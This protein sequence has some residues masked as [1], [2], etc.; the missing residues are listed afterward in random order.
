M[1]ALETVVTRRTSD[2]EP[3]LSLLAAALGEGDRSAFLPTAA[4]EAARFLGAEACEVWLE[5]EGPV[6]AAVYRRPEAAPRSPDPRLLRRAQAGDVVADEGWL[7]V[8]VPGAGRTQG[9]LA[10]SHPAGT[11]LGNGGAV[12]D[13]DAL[14]AARLVAALVGLAQLGLGTERFDAEARDQFLALVGHDLRSPL[15]N[16]RVGAQL[17]RRN[18]D[19]GDL[20]SVREALG[21][22]E[23]Q[24]DRLLA[25]LEALLE[26]IAAAG[27]RLI[28]LQ[29]LDLAAM[30]ETIVGP[31]R[32]AAEERGT[33]TVF[34]VQPSPQPL[35]ARGDAG[36][37][38]Q[39][40]EQLVD[41]AAKYASG[42][43]ITI[44]LR[45]AGPNVRLDVCDDGPGIRPEDVERV[46]APFGR[47]RSAGEKQGFGLGLYL[48]RNIVTAHG[49]RLWI[50]RTSRSGTCMALSLPAVET[51]GP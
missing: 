47:G 32:L 35:L 31:H 1:A 45:P 16:V 5:D 48:A 39:V 37:I 8:P 17:A 36:Q 34:T 23:S 2:L 3:V 6:L 42:G 12:V 10:F 19:A 7:L 50:A 11:A 24:S 21:I 9:A 46:F 29:P 44:T 38:A 4:R 13:E 49:G 18:L 30:A 28:R 33:G 26:A 15:A 22:I 41:N 40:V 43:H 14:D 51:D 20:E 27:H 25:R